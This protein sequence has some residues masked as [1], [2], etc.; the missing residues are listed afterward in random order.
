MDFNLDK[1]LSTRIEAWGKAHYKFW[2][3]C[4]VQLINGYALVWVIFGL[5]GWLAWWVLPVIAFSAWLLAIS[6]QAIVARERPKFEQKTG[7]QMW[8]RTYAFPSGHATISSA[9]ATV[10][11]LA[12]VGPSLPVLI[13]LGVVFFIAEILIGLGRIVVGVHYLGDVLVGFGV[14]IAFGVMFSVL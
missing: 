2:Y 7:Y 13:A 6:T 12:S 11:L 8:W 3:W 5:L 9:V 1:P 14:G 10:I 4:A